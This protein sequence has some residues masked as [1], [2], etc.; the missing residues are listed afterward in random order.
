MITVGYIWN[1]EEIFKASWSLF[2]HDGAAAFKLSEWSPLPPPLC[3]KNLAEGRTQWLIGRRIRSINRHP[4]EIDE[5]SAPECISDTEDWPHWNVD[6]DNPNYR[7]DDC[8]ADIEF[9]NEQDNSI[10]EPDCPQQR[11]VSATPNVPGLIGPTWNSKRQAD[12][13]LMTVNTIQTR[14]KRG[15]KT[16]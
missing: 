4:V 15:A 12:R 3:V 2:Q 10:E 16:I 13:V 9:D 11:K 14:M 5:D 6:L 7:K 1:T 8:G